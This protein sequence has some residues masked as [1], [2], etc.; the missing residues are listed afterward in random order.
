MKNK[1][2]ARNMKIIGNLIN[3][4]IKSEPIQA[5]ILGGSVARGDETKHS[6]IDIVFYVNKADMP[7]DSRRFYKFK[8]K[9][10]EEHYSSTESLN[11]RNLLPEEKIIY[12]KIKNLKVPKFDKGV[13]RARLVVETKKAKKFQKLAVENFKKGNFEKAF[14][15]LFSME[16]PSFVLMHALPPS[17][18]LPFPTFRLFESVKKFDKKIYKIFEELFEFEDKDSRKILKRF[19][20]IYKKVS[21]ERGSEGFYDPLKVNYNLK[22]LKRT[23]KKYPFFYSYRFILSCVVDWKLSNEFGIKITKPLLRNKLSIS[24]NLIKI[25]EERR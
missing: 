3:K 8:G 1:L 24:E 13:A 23:F 4:K 15:Y 16:S 11:S 2:H 12:T 10:I 25:I 9:Y 14:Y 22:E 17:Y 20:K 5:V 18:N 6:D 21:V 19:G 7:K